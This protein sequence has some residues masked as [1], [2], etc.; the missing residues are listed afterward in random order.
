MPMR[1]SRLCGKEILAVQMLTAILLVVISTASA[2][3][4]GTPEFT[5]TWKQDNDRCQPKRKGG[6]TLRIEHH[7]QEL[8]VETS[9]S[10]IVA[11]SRHAIQKYTTDGRVS[12]STGADGDTFYTS[13][14]W[15]DTRLIF[16]IEEHE[17]SRV[18]P[19][20]ETWSLLENGAILQRIRERQNNERQILV[21]RRIPIDGA[22]EN[23]SHSG[24]AK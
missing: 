20:K 2:F 13:V 8:T 6:V 19:S 4:Q 9:I 3:A 23:P 15:Q 14:I 18:L 22:N 5:G 12:P 7:G 11:A 17:N 21:F 1:R 24:G 10:N 16:S